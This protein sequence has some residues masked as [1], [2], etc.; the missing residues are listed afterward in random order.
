MRSIEFFYDFGSPNAYL[1]HKVLPGLAAQ[2]GASVVYKPILLGGVFKATK[3]KP[4]M[5]AFADVE[6]KLAYQ[7]TEILRFIR[8]N[9]LVFHMNP[10]F[11]V[12]TMAT[13]RGAAFA[14]GK[15]WEKSYIDAVF[16]AMWVHGQKL[17]EADVLR[18]V[19]QEAGL[20]A[21]EIGDAIASPPVKRA[22]IDATEDAVARGVF[23]SPTMFVESEMFFGK[24]SLPDLV[25][26]LGEAA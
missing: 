11:P 10:Y 7:R 17:D 25:W 6:P 15:D 24:D 21:E 19:L 9:D 26:H 8:R 13:M 22:L 4:P 5:T 20:P 12:M 2:N 16:D 1:V 3:N 14:T 18:S 23:G